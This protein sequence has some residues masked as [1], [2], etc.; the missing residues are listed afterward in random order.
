MKKVFKEFHLNKNSK[1][2]LVFSIFGALTLGSASTT[3]LFM[4]TQSNTDSTINNGDTDG[5]NT[6]SIDPIK[7]K[8]FEEV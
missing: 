2:L 6:D 8:L 3:I 4:Q 7:N 5:S 1:R